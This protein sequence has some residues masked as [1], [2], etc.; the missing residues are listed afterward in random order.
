M[1]Q[2]QKQKKA[3]LNEEITEHSNHFGWVRITTEKFNNAQRYYCKNYYDKVDRTVYTLAEAKGLQLRF[4]LVG[5]F[6][7]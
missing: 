6:R 1:H 5:S 7:Y 4:P 2:L 3:T